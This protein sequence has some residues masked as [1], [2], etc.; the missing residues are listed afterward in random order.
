MFL[1]GDCLSFYNFLFPEAP[2][3]KNHQVWRLVLVPLLRIEIPAKPLVVKS[4]EVVSHFH[5]EEKV[6]T[7][8]ITWAAFFPSLKPAWPKAA[9]G[10]SKPALGVPW[11]IFRF[12]RYFTSRSRQQL[13][14]C[15]LW[16]GLHS[17]QAP[18]GRHP[19]PL[20]PS[21][22]QT[23]LSLCI[24]ESGSFSRFLLLTPI[25]SGVPKTTPGSVIR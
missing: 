22:Y 19:P 24:R 20:S 9:R 16:W 7:K 6:K 25:V 2:L 1:S 17:H 14:C 18:E 12:H 4:K 8:G 13:G 3:C 5:L 23:M 11:V 15:F 10:S 21:F